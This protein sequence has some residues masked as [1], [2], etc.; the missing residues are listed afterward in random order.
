V[1]ITWAAA[2]KR[3]SLGQEVIVGLNWGLLEVL[4]ARGRWDRVFVD[5]L[6]SS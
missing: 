2:C 4:T 5:S 3:A 1:V 6:I